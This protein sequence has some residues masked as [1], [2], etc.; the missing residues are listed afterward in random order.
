MDQYDYVKAYEYFKM[1]YETDKSFTE[2]KRKMEIYR[3]LIG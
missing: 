3:P 1:A 2:A